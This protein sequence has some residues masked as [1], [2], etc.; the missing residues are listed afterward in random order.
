MIQSIISHYGSLDILV[1]NAGIMKVGSLASMTKR[2]FIQTMDINFEGAL[3]TILLSLPFMKRESRIVNITSIG[4]VVSVPH[5]LP[6]NSAK[7][8]LV[9]LS[10]GLKA[11]LQKRGIKVT[12]V[13]PGLMRTGS[14]LNASFKGKVESEFKW[15]SLGA[16]LPLISISAERAG[17]MIV[18]ACKRGNTLLVIG[19]PAK[20]ARLL[21]SIFPA[22]GANF[23]GLINRFL[24]EID[25][26]MD[27]LSNKNRILKGKEIPTPFKSSKFL[28]LGNKAAIQFKEL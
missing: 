11:E 27:T 19:A 4:G 23:M 18:S 7:F 10:L 26:Q 22:F 1:N 6:Y 16:S 2:D 17:N 28:S 20:F 24:P 15:F 14:F 25:S 8:A 3:N 21:F 9:G 13:I 5:L 12:T